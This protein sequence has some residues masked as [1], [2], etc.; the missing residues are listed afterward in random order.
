MCKQQ[1]KQQQVR[2]GKEAGT[3][4]GRGWSLPKCE[5]PNWERTFG[6]TTRSRFINT[7]HLLSGTFY[8][9]YVWPPSRRREVFINPSFITSRYLFLCLLAARTMP[10]FW[11]VQFKHKRG[12]V[13]FVGPAV[14]CLCSLLRTVLVNLPFKPW[15]ASLWP[16][17][18]RNAASWPRFMNLLQLV[19]EDPPY[20]GKR[21]EPC[22]AL[23]KGL[24][25]FLRR[26]RRGFLA[27][28][29]K[30]ESQGTLSRD[31]SI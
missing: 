15:N 26:R 18:L 22:S 7:N 29:R 9:E 21:F 20:S 19:L 11:A 6:K 3:R 16:S 14:N 12:W 27:W 8:S 10:S 1:Y 13:F 30:W 23:R 28:V 31:R 17:P 25:V 5:I 4:W 2:S 24:N